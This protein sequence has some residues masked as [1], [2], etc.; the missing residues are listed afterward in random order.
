MQEPGSHYVFRIGEDATT[1]KLKDDRHAKQTPSEDEDELTQEGH[2]LKDMLERDEGGESWDEH[3]HE[4]EHEH[5]GDDDDDEDEDEDEDECN[6]DDGEDEDEGARVRTI[7]RT[8]RTGM[9]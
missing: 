5:E 3:E 2:E 7:P 6:D 4:N 8:I 9:Q 1:L